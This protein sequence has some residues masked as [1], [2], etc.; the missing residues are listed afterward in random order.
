MDIK[1]KSVGYSLNGYVLRFLNFNKGRRGK[2]IF[3]ALQSRQTLKV[4]QR[5]ESFYCATLLTIPTYETS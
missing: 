2:C 5:I 4:G 1:Q 3:T